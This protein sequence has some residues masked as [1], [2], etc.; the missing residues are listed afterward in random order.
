MRRSSMYRAAFR[1]RERVGGGLNLDYGEYLTPE[2]ALSFD[3]PLS[4][5]GPGDVSRWMAVPWQSDTDSCRSG[6][7]NTPF[8]TD[9]FIPTFWPSRVPNHVLT[10]DQYRTAVDETQ[11]LEKRLEAFYTRLYWLRN[12]NYNDP[13]AVQLQAMVDRF[14]ELGVVE[15]REHDSGPALPPVMYVETLPARVQR[16]PEPPSDR[17]QAPFVSDEFATGR[18]PRRNK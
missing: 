6:Y 13:T 11:P 1:L 17:R 10:E 2:V 18:F 9:E 4:A 5:S 8:P 3:G 15:R 14:G 16:V 12:L 7:P